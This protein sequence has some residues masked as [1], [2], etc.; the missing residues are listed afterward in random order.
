MKPTLELPAPF[1][2]SLGTNYLELL[3]KPLKRLTHLD[4]SGA[5]HREGFGHL[6][7]KQEPP[8][9]IKLEVEICR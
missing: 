7:K 8:F 1:V 9:A 6:V 5:E 2:H 4:L 3:L